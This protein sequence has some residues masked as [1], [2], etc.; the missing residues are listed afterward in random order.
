[1]KEDGAPMVRKE[2]L[3]GLLA[4]T[5]DHHLPFSEKQAAACYEHISLMLAWNRRCNLT[6][7]TNHREIIEKHLL[8]S[9]L[10]ARWLPGAGPIMDVG[11]GPGFPGIPLAILQ[12]ERPVLLLEANRKKASFLR[13][14][15]AHLSLPNARVLEGRWEGLV[16]TSRPLLTKPLALV[17]MRAVKLAPAHLTGLASRLL[18]EDGVFAYWAGPSADPTWQEKHRETLAAV[19]MV[20]EARYRYSLPSLSEPRYLLLWRRQP[21]PAAGADGWV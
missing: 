17:T 2:F 20:F 14:L 3:E 1:M 12:P 11:T 6:R 16:Q 18:R 15:L 7:I 4:L 21:R 9:L 8:D 5:A 19:G 10:P 13:V